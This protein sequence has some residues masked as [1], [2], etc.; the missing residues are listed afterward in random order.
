MNIMLILVNG[1]YIRGDS[2]LPDVSKGR[3]DRARHTWTGLTD[4]KANTG[5]NICG[6]GRDHLL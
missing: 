5:I 2:P 4:V 6:I 1:F 3:P